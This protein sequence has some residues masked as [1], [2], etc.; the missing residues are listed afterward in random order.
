METELKYGNDLHRIQ[1]PNKA[2]VTVLKPNKFPELDSIA[3]ALQ[4]ALAQPNGSQPLR[5]LL[6]EKKPKNIAIA[7][8]D[9]TR[10]VPVKDILPELIT[11]IRSALPELNAADVN[12]IIGGGLH[13]PPDQN[14]QNR[15]LP[16]KIVSGYPILTHDA[17]NSRVKDFGTTSRGTP[18]KINSAYA[19]A[20]F[21]MVV[22]QID[23]HQFVGFT[24]GAK[25]VAI[26]CASTETIEHNHGLMFSEYARVGNLNNNPVREDLNEAGR[27]IGL[28]FVI[29]VI[30][31]A[32]KKVVRI[33]AG[34]P[35]EVLNRG[36][37]TCAAV[38]GV[39]LSH[40]FDIVVA[41]CGGLPKDI[42]LYQAQKGLNLASH[43]V[44]RG[45]QIL[46]LAACTQG[47]GDDIYFDYVCQ[48]ATPGEVLQDFKMLGFKMG[49]HKA[50]LFGR[51]LAN[52]D[53]AVL[54][55]LDPTILRKCQLRAA[56]PSNIISEW[57]DG[58]A[59]KP[60]LAI[61]PDAN[62]TY[63]YASN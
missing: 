21:K 17:K 60:Q 49:A 20:E 55:D 16:Q 25:G 14:A 15:I 28:D 46:L 35:E 29:N 44:K 43:A 42:S 47:V 13:A 59:Y 22:G 41:S 58:F 10:P 11:Q 3:D 12:I 36:S 63:F 37:K 61:I 1:I 24:G 62:T 6:Q 48:F 27:M 38:Y 31:N 23:P 33:L 8:P 30:M 52:Y 7:I 53:V 45:G 34:D 54:S 19:S 9:E 56:E 51:T 18:V 50:Y 39:R 4:K 57:V 40:K 5:K 2:E 32:D 26:G